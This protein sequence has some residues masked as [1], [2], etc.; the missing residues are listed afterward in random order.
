VVLGSGGEAPN[1]VTLPGGRVQDVAA[2]SSERN[3]GYLSGVLV[4]PG[5]VDDIGVEPHDAAVA[6]INDRPLTRGQLDDVEAF[7][8]DWQFD[9]GP[10][11]NRAVSARWSETGPTAAQLELILAG[12]A[13]VFAV[14]VVGATLALA[15]A[16]SREERD[17]LTVTGVAPGMLARAAAARAWLLAVIGAAMAVPVGLLPVAV[18][19]AADDGVMRFVVPWRAVGL[20]GLALPA[21]AAAVA[22][23]ASATAQRLRPVRVST[24]VFE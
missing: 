17:V 10:S 24:A 7:L 9:Q 11:T 15:A 20:V 22:L 1:Q 3:L 6:Y 18:L 23:A 5:L 16:E 13:L 14:L 8:E 12:A 19:V 2:V 21:I 4:S